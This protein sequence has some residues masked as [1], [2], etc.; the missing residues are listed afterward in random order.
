VAAI[1][2]DDPNPLPDLAPGLQRLVGQCLRKDLN[3]RYQ[4]MADVRIALEDLKEESQAATVAV[5][6]RR[7]RAVLVLGVLVILGGA[8]GGT[9]FALKPRAVHPPPPAT[10]VTFDGRLAMNPSISADGKYVAYASDRAGQ[11]NLDIW[12]QALSNGEPVR[13]TNDKF[14][15]DLPSFSPDGTK[16]AFRSN[17]DGGGIYVIPVL[18][19]QP[20]RLL[21]KNGTRPLYSPDGNY[22]LFSPFTSQDVHHVFMM[23]AEGGE[24]RKLEVPAG[25]R[26]DLPIWSPNG[27]QI[28]AVRG[29]T[30]VSP[31]T[32]WFFLPVGGGPP[33]ISYQR[34]SGSGTPL[35][36]LRDGRILFSALSGDAFNLWLAQLS[37]GDW[38]IH[39]PFER[40]TFGTG[41]ITSASVAGNSTVVFSST[42]APTR[43]WSLPL[44]K[45]HQ[46]SVGDLLAFPST[47]SKDYF[48]SLS[49]NG[50]MAYVSQKSG[51]WNL[52][53]RDLHNGTETW[54][55]SFEGTNPYNVSVVIKP[56]GSR[57]A[58][59]SCTEEADCAIFTVAAAGGVPQKICAHCGQVRAWSSDG[60]A[61]ASQEATVKEENVQES[62]ILRIDPLTGRKT[63]IAENS[64]LLL[65]APDLSPDGHWV[66]FQ[67]SGQSLR[68]AERL[69]V[70]PWDAGA[71]V[72]PGRWIAITGLDH[73]D[74]GP[75]WSRDGKTLYFMSNR[76]GSNCLWAVRL[77]PT[78]KKPIG[79]PYAVR[80]FHASPRQY[81]DAVWPI[82]SI[83]PDRIVIALEQ[84]Q[85]DL[86]MIQLPEA[87]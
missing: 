86:W 42:T 85:S 43:L 60:K 55:A 71:P 34:D 38:R 65:F 13:L 80:H 37:P 45:D 63:L 54:L 50:K 62:H 19:G 72:E 52:F 16:I 68:T 31:P 27:S 39:E 64:G 75:T 22:L 76:D 5:P 18:S 33:T 59:S 14:N 36:W 2:R 77:D 83:G 82:F 17:R 87:R 15:D 49:A 73:F 25:R 70:A 10:Q 8:A 12:V 3:R 58:Y 21:V 23:P 46:P 41:Q 48:P 40:L 56:D 79:E 67:A 11:G 26:F 4:S 35:A 32:T 6:K 74:S 44:P 53:I 78:T 24:P 28:M 57:V 20:P 61:M 29:R 66:A 69:F 47:G 84:V 1:L 81:S 51:K 30:P 9:W 7:I